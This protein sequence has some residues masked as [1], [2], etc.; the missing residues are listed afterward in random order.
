MKMAKASDADMDMA[1][2]LTAAIEALAQRWAPTMPAAA[3]RLRGDDD[4]AERFDQHDDEQC[5]RALRHLLEIANRGS[6]GRVVW[7]MSVLLDPRN[8]MV[9]P[10]A[11]TLEHHPD[12]AAA[13]KARPTFTD[14]QLVD[15]GRAY[16][17]A[18]CS[19]NLSQAVRAMREALARPSVAREGQTCE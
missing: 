17:A 10:A 5:G 7:G 18:A 1:L 15:A 11:D 6:L 3:Q 4:D 12:V 16:M 13:L 8:Q 2:E 19:S 14:Q 9:D